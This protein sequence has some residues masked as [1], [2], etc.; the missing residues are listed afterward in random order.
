MEEGE[1]PS[2]SLSRVVVS[3]PADRDVIDIWFHIAADN[4]HAADLLVAEFEEKF[5]LLGS[6]PDIGHVRTDLPFGVRC[7]PVGKYLIIY[8]HTQ[9]EVRILR[10]LHGA[11]L[12]ESLV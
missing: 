9:D 7:F 5:A 3:R 1:K 10:V 8:R 2:R 12:L 4:I 6:T 11:R